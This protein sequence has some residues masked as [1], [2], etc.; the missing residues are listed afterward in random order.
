MLSPITE[1]EFKQL[2]EQGYNR[3]PL[4]VETFEVLYS[5]WQSYL[6]P[7]MG[8]VEAAH[9]SKAELARMMVGAEIGEVK[10]AAKGGAIRM[11]IKPN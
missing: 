11:P 8:T 1:Q 6:K 3:I 5:A 7:P 2:A 10:T 9:T 4:V